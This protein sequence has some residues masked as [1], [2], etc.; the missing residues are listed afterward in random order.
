MRDSLLSTYHAHQLPGIW[1][2]DATR[3]W[4]WGMD[5]PIVDGQIM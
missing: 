1:E 3:N 5:P 2:I 4:Q